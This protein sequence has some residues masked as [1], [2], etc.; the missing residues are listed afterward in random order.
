MNCLNIALGKGRVAKQ[1]MER[2]QECGLVFP[3]YSEKSRKLIFLDST[4]CV[5]VTLVK[6]P[7][8]PIYVEKGAA[9]LGVV[10]KDILLEGSYDIY[11]LMN[12]NIGRCD[13]ATAKLADAVI[14]DNKRL[15]VGTKYPAIAKKYFADRDRIIHIIHLN[16]S[17]EL[18]PIVGLS[19]I[20]VDI[21]ESG[22]TLEE[23]GLV[24]MEKFMTISSKLISN[25]V[26]LKTKYKQV[27]KIIDIMKA[28]NE[29]VERA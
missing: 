19:D 20:I 7:D 10:G 26:A 3:D 11:E 27:E 15:I 23:N 9:D 28:L 12:L 24:V 17:V 13:M 14:D 25:K 21:V 22:K 2:F 6:S 8:V 18:A 1:S 29:E 4:G 5:Q 16:G